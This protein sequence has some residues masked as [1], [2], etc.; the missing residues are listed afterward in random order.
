MLTIYETDGESIAWER[1]GGTF[2]PHKRFREG[3]IPWPMISH[4]FD[5]YGMTFEGQ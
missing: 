4:V 3:A 2:R 1:G 5:V